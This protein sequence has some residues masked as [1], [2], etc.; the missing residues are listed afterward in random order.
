M[1]MIQR[2]FHMKRELSVKIE[3]SQEILR[4]ILFIFFSKNENKQFKQ[5]DILYA[6]YN[7][8][9]LEICQK[10]FVASTELEYKP[11]LNTTTDDSMCFTNELCACIFYKQTK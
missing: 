7:I 10:Y 6:L 9:V 8:I 3:F 11:N 2:G 1:H 4:K 5:T